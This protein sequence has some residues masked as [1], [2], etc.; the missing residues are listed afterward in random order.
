M[1]PLALEDPS[2]PASPVEMLK[3]ERK[4]RRQRS[5]DLSP[6]TL[7]LNL[8]AH[9]GKTRIPDAIAAGLAA[10]K[11]GAAEAQAGFRS[12][13]L[14]CS[15]AP[16]DQ[17]L[18]L[19]KELAAGAFGTVY[20]V[21]LAENLIKNGKDYGTEFAFKALLRTDPHAPDPAAIEARKQ[22]IIQEFQISAALTK[23]S[24]VMQVYELAQIENEFGM[25]CEKI[26]GESAGDIMRISKDALKYG[27]IDTNDYL[28]MVKRVISDV[29]VAVARCADEGV[30]HADISPNNVMYDREEK[31]FRLIDFGHGR[32]PGQPRPPGTWGYFNFPLIADQT[33]DVYSAGQLL[34]NFIR[35]PEWRIE[36]FN[37]VPPSLL[38]VDSFNFAEKLRDIP[39][40]QREMMLSAIL[41]MIRPRASAAQSLRDDFFEGVPS[42]DETHDCYER[43]E[44]WQNVKPVYLRGYQCFEEIEDQFYRD[45]IYECLFDLNDALCDDR[46][47]DILQ[48]LD[49]LNEILSE[50]E[51]R[52]IR[53]AT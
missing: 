42:R 47:D 16:G 20:A 14:A 51:Q 22:S 11:P 48:I 49:R 13:K 33:N 18:P 6:D 26:N 25:L 36:G 15:L 12:V 28:Q 45:K 37:G 3:N 7:S 46:R 30:V 19:K 29:L 27:F 31:I 41:R 50:V 8:V 53:E 23:T 17:G 1:K 44:L 43:L 40:G 32:E 2:E 38:T 52:Q 39:L 21:T 5:T 9:M 24:R 10:L 4:H 34:A 35:D